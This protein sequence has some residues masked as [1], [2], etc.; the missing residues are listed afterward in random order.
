M[1]SE[2]LIKF[3]KEFPNSKYREIH[4]QYTGPM[5]SDA[6]KEKYQKSK[7]PINSKIMSFNEIKDTKNRIG[8]IVPKDYI[9]IDIDSKNNAR[10]VFDI[11]QAMKINFSYMTGRKGGHFIFKNLRK[12]K[13][14][15]AGLP[16]SIGITVD[17]KKGILFY[18][19]TIQIEN[20]VKFQIT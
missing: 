17:V 16:C 18:L 13:S 20:G 10:I 7:A 3:D 19:K 4:A 11:L 12:I 6:D 2:E 1:A 14:I 5:D 8:W 9:V 15:S